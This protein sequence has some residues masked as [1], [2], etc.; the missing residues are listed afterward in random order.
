MSKEQHQ[1]PKKG[2]QADETLQEMDAALIQGERFVEKYLKQILGGAAAVILLVL[3]VFA[4]LKF[5]KEPAEHK[6]A[7]SIFTAEDRFINS[8]DLRSHHQ[9]ALWHAIG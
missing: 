8:Q 7:E 3:G 1:N 6:A 4:Y 9:G 2:W 5:V